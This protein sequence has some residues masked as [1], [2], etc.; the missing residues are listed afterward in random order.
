ME[1]HSTHSEKP[2]LMAGWSSRKWRMFVYC[3]IAGTIAC[4]LAYLDMPTPQLRYD[5]LNLWI[6]F[7]LIPTAGG[8]NASNLYQD[9]LKKKYQDER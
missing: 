7:V 2:N 6:V 1:K 4:A 5:V 9:R 3:A 8:Y